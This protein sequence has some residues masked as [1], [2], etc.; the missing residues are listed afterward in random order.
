[1]TVALLLST[2]T[3]RAWKEWALHTHSSSH[4][5]GLTLPPAH[6]RGIFISINSLST[7]IISD[8]NLKH[9]VTMITTL[10]DEKLLWIEHHLKREDNF[11]NSSSWMGVTSKGVLLLEICV[12]LMETAGGP[13]CCLTDASSPICLC[14]TGS[15]SHSAETWWYLL[16]LPLTKDLSSRA[17]AP[18]IKPVLHPHHGSGTEVHLGLS[19]RLSLSWNHDCVTDAAGRDAVTVLPPATVLI[20]LSLCMCRV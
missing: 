16:T 15:Y 7:W 13:R 4:K 12:L 10:S 9:S 17:V 5:H 1:M 3:E 20:Q 2:E 18:S 6:K 8:M 14:L 11:R 19:P